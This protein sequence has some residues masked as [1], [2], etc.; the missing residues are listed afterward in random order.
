MIQSLMSLGV[1]PQRV[2]KGSGLFMWNVPLPTTED[3]L[4]MA[5]REL[6]TKKNSSYGPSMKVGEGPF[7]M[8]Y[9]QILGDTSDKLNV[10][11]RFDIMFD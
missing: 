7:F 8:Q 2:I 4:E 1:K 10:E 5:R 9:G 6:I 3:C 11:W